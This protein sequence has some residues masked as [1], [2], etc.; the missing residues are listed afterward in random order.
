MSLFETFEAL[1]S[2]FFLHFK[3]YYNIALQFQ[4]ILNFSLVFTT[5]PLILF[6][7]FID[8]SSFDVFYYSIPFNVIQLVVF[9]SVFFQP[10]IIFFHINQQGKLIV[11]DIRIYQCLSILFNLLMAS[12]S[13]LS[14]FFILSIVLKDILTILS[15]HRLHLTKQA[16]SCQHIRV[17]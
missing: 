4:Q 2:V 11:A 17:L 13:N 8:S 5:L 7:H 1:L 15:H 6:N 16:K 10:K 3:Q 14:V 12:K 9:C